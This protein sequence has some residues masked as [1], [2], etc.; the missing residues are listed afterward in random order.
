MFYHPWGLPG[1]Q[2]WEHVIMFTPVGLIWVVEEATASEKI[3]EI[4]TN[5]VENIETLDT[6][7]LACTRLRCGSRRGPAALILS[8]LKGHTAHH[9]Q[10]TKHLGTG[11]CLPL[12]R[13]CSTMT[14]SEGLPFWIPLTEI[15]AP[16]V[17]HRNVG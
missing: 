5:L 8:Y 6:K 14:W 12:H 9:H 3:S 11:P 17:C 10:E 1:S 4:H 13:L 16:E 7:Q 15:N 2:D